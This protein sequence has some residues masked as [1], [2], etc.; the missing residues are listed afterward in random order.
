[1]NPKESVLGAGSNPCASQAHKVAENLVVVAD[2]KRVNLDTLR[3]Q[4]DS[5]D[6]LERCEFYN[7]GQKVVTRVKSVLET[8]EGMDRDRCPAVPLSALVIDFQM[9]QKNGIQVVKE[10]SDLYDLHGMP[11]KP[12]FLFV[13]AHGEN[14]AFREYCLEQGVDK[15]YEKPLQSAQLKQLK[16]LLKV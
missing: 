16:E 5:I 6:V 15:V 3:I 1:M 13:T 2:D 7:D 4:L 9:P 10:V 11:T 8:L 12:K 14:R